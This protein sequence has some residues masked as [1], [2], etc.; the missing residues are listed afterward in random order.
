LPLNENS[1][2]YKQS[3]LA[4]LPDTLALGSATPAVYGAVALLPQS[5]A[6]IEMP[7]GEI[8]FETRYMFYSTTHWRPIVN[9]YSGGAPD[10]YGLWS[11]RLKD[12][13]DLPEPAWHA[14]E[15]SGATHVI[16]HEDGYAGDR[17]RQVSNWVR[18][19]GGQELSVFGADH[20]FKV[21]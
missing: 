3:G 5:S 7:F 21:R 20:L 14:V 11:E 17:G 8:A 18:A 16:V 15:E 9:G 13:F 12:V 19:H 6:L 2:D 4:P 1:T 10:R